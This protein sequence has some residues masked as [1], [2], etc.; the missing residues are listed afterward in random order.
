[1]TPSLDA[2]NIR[3]EHSRGRKRKSFQRIPMKMTVLSRKVV[4]GD[5]EAAA[6]DSTSVPLQ[7]QMPTAS[8]SSSDR[9]TSHASLPKLLLDYHLPHLGGHLDHFWGLSTPETTGNARN[10]GLSPQLFTTIMLTS[11][12][13][14]RF[15]PHLLLSAPSS[16]IPTKAISPPYLQVSFHLVLG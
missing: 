13:P 9:D 10:G 5:E 6:S 2:L 15:I 8:S 7:Q 12:P 14:S 16:K 1:M 11:W 3:P 4:T